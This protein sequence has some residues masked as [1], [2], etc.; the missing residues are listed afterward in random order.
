MNGPTLGAPSLLSGDPGNTSVAFNG[1]NQHVSIADAPIWNLTGDLTIEAL[2]NVTEGANY[3]TIVA[4]NSATTDSSTFELRVEAS[5]AGSSS[6]SGR[7]A[8]RTRR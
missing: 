3:R 2:I 7:P 1:T 8:A 4:K 5:T 6:S